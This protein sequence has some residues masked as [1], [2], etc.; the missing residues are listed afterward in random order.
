VLMNKVIVLDGGTGREL[1]R[2]GIPVDDILWSCKALLTSPEGVT[3]VH[4]SYIESG[5]QII[6]TNSYSIIPKNLQKAGIEDQMEELL[7][8]AAECAHNARKACVS[9]YPDVK[10]AGCIPPVQ[11]SYRKENIY[12]Y[13]E[14]LD[15]Y[16]K[17][18]KVMSPHVDLF[19]AET[20]SN[21]T[22]G[23]AAATAANEV[24]KEVWTSFVLSDL[25]GPDEEPHLLSGETIQEVMDKLNGLKISAILFNCSLPAAISHAMP[26]LRK[27][28]D[29][30]G[31]SEPILVG[32][33]GNS[34]KPFPKDYDSENINF[35]ELED[36]TEEQYG[37][38]V[39]DWISQG[40][41]I[42][43]GCCGIGPEHI[44]YISSTLLKE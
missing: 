31:C 5:A 41:N 15:T 18:V 21:A 9:Q 19:L 37:E 36:V 42:V 11:E 12:T 29:E 1:K 3:E 28:V 40:A 20:L 4:K 14:I 26:Y 6:T 30:L 2:R 23:K 34:F 7:L 33:Y 27:H 13:D 8:K 25:F 44:N 32:A 22:L 43:G 38:Y 35:R 39:T 24:G 17:I 10:I 16:R